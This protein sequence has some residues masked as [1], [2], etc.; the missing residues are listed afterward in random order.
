MQFREFRAHVHAQPGVEVRQRLVH[1]ECGR[2]A[3]H[4]PPEGDPL[5]LA[6]G[7]LPGLAVQ[8]VLDFERPGRVTDRR[9]QGL[10]LAATSGHQGA[11]QR[12]A[13]PETQ[14]AHQ[15]RCRQVLAHG[16]VRVE[17]VR[18]E[19]HGEVATARSY[20][21]DHHF[22]DFHVARGLRLEPR[23]D[24][25][26]RRLPAAGGTDQGQELTVGDVEIDAV[27]DPRVAEGLGDSPES[28]ARQGSIPPSKLSE[29]RHARARRESGDPGP[30]PEQSDRLHDPSSAP[31]DSATRKAVTIPSVAPRIPTLDC[32]SGRISCPR[33]LRGTARKLYRRL[34]GFQ[35]P[36]GSS[37]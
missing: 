32:R 12:K 34:P 17:R 4:R 27:E 31:L 16:Q 9:A 30:V 15:E 21:V 3:H 35:T 14:I 8:Q 18:L 6:T 22:V 2:I 37:E 26:G 1:Q 7:E 36:R 23:D 20:V 24:P 33:L 11:Q 29:D 19:H 13:F 25:Q 28:D 10:E 5:A